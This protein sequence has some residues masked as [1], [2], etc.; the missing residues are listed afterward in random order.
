MVY[1]VYYV[2]VYVVVHECILCGMYMLIWCV[3][4]YACCGVYISVCVCTCM[5]GV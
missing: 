3:V 1:G 4:V 2:S 5:Y